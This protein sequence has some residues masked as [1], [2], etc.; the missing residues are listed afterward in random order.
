MNSSLIDQA[1]ELASREAGL[2]VVVTYRS[3]GSA[4]GSVVNAG[5]MTHPLTGEP[6]ITFVVMG[7]EAAISA[8][9]HAR[10]LTAVK[11]SYRPFDALST[12]AR[13]VTAS[14]AAS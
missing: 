2:S 1:R 3:D 11:R 7:H 12:T 9:T 6:A 4:Q 5:V 8:T 14:R 10:S 13:G